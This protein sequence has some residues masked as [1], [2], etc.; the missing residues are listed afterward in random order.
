MP[1]F[2]AYFNPPKYS[3]TI[4]NPPTAS[5]RRKS[6]LYPESWPLIINGLLLNDEFKSLMVSFRPIPTKIPFNMKNESVRNG[7]LS[8]LTPKFLATFFKFTTYNRIAVFINTMRCRGLNCARMRHAYNSLPPPK[9]DNGQQSPPCED[10]FGTRGTKLDL[11][12]CKCIPICAAGKDYYA[13]SHFWP[14]TKCLTKAE[15]QVLKPT[16]FKAFEEMQKSGTKTP[17]PTQPTS[18]DAGGMTLDNTISIGGYDIPILYVGVG[19]VV[20]VALF[21]IK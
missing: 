8:I 13:A 7:L 18:T 14:D 19:A 3:A 20:L 10:E 21:M 1:S 17:T 11:A 4:N 16:E 6:C 15:Y 5:C 2:D 9:C 12:T